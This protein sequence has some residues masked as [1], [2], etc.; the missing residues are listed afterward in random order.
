MEN[1][2]IWM[3]IFAGA[4]IGLLGT[5]LIASERELNVKRKE[6]DELAVKLGGEGAT[7][8]LD[9]PTETHLADSD[10]PP[11]LLARNQELLDEMSL[12]THRLESSHKR[13]EELETA[14]HH[15][16]GTEVENNQLQASN[17]LL[18]EE[19]TSLKAQ[20]QAIRYQLEMSNSHHQ[21]IVGRNSQL[22]AE[23]AALKGK[24]DESQA[25]VRDLNGA[26]ERLANVES[27]ETAFKDQQHQLEV[28]VSELKNQLA[29]TQTKLQGLEA[30]RNRLTEMERLHQEVR[31]ENRRLQEE[32]SRSRERLAE[33]EENERRL[34]ILRQHLEELQTKQA[35][36]TESNRQFQDD[37]AAV[38]NVLTSPPKSSDP[39]PLFRS[40]AHAVVEA[41]E[42]ESVVT[43]PNQEK[44]ST[45]GLDATHG[46]DPGSQDQ[47]SAQP[48]A[49]FA[50]E[51]EIA[52]TPPA[53]GT[54]KAK[55]RSGIFPAAL[56]ILVAGGALS[57]SFLGKHAEENAPVAPVPAAQSSKEQAAK[58]AAAQKESVSLTDADTAVV[59][60]RTE[61]QNP[62]ARN[63]A[64]QDADS[65]NKG[66]DTV[67]ATPN[68]MTAE[69]A[70]GK[71]AVKPAKQASAAAKPAQ[72]GWGSYQIVRPT[73]VFSEPRD[74]S[75][76]IANV[77]PGLQVNVVDTRDGWL[78]IR[79]KHGR[80]PGFIRKEAAVRIGRN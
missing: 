30:A 35:A 43:P 42:N 49:K 40:T 3:L 68:K 36:L 1:M 75:Q 74:D 8:R 61:P 14:H 5:F 27:C 18:Q 70:V 65:R 53:Q 22:E 12:L 7:N 26:R 25:R 46:N 44:Y 80:P 72:A 76:L 63:S 31:E 51:A 37:L 56:A 13:I 69:P 39:S 67:L 71:S 16:S 79:S 66:G 60:N 32:I 20:L 47:A 54:K 6:V 73:R 11:D 50:S 45:G 64:N 58:T 77:E 57:A 21:E 24:L 4:A 62:K 38:A 59:D 55:R 34:D 10:A 33:N 52:N 29:A 48:S 41:T 78:E 9:N 19:I 23:I 17:Q 15:L 28:Q 2:F